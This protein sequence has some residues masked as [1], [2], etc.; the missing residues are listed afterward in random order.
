MVSRLLIPME[1]NRVALIEFSG[2]ERKGK[3]LPNEKS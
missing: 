3:F 2:L 1:M